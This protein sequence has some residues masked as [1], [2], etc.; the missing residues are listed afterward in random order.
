MYTPLID[1]MPSDPSTMMTAMVKAQQ[2]TNSYGQAVTVFTNDQQ[3]YRVVV[4]I[5]WNS[6]ELFPDSYARLGG[7]H[8]L[9]SFGGSVVVLIEN[10]GL[11][12]ILSSAFAGVSK[13][14][15][16][17]KI[18]QNTRPLRLV[19]EELLRGVIVDVNSQEELLA[20]L[21]DLAKN[22][23][24]S[25]LWLDCWIKPVFIMMMFIQAEREADWALHLTTVDTMMPYFFC[26]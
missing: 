14:L 17:K 23:R 22:S 26:S 7:M 10:S 15:S 16:G 9:M 20:K 21:E 13:L 12:E 2:L 19:T 8:M 3:L 24:T 5:L 4:D 1:M 6:P 18:L 25:K 11:E